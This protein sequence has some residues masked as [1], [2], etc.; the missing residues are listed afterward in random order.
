MILPDLNQMDDI[1]LT[2]EEDDGTETECQLICLF[3][4]K[5]HAY[6]ALTPVGDVLDEVYL[7]AAT[8]EDQGDEFEFTIENIEDDELLDELGDVF[9][10]IMEN[11]M[12]DE[13]E[14]VPDINEDLKGASIDTAG[15]DDG[16]SHERVLT[17]EDDESYWDQFINKKLEDI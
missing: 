9:T 6:A 1:F 17:G 4:H 10:S 2:I 13:D 7:F 12:E 11:A 3:E 14:D 5:D 16:E 8:V 15:K